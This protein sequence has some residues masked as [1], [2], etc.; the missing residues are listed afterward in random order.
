M[1]I[2]LLPDNIINQ[3]AAGEVIERPFSVVKELVENAIDAGAENIQ[4]YI[5]DGGKS[6]IKIVDDGIGMSPD[7]MQ[8][9]LMRHATSKLLD[10]DLFAIKSLGFRGEALPSIASVS[11][12]T[13]SSRAKG[14]NEAWQIY[15]EGGV[16]ND[17]IPAKQPQK[18]TI[19]EINDLF[20]ATPA[21]LKFLRSDRAEVM[22]ITDVINRLAMVHP[23]ISFTF[24]DGDK[25]KFSY[26]T[27]QNTSIL[28]NSDDD[29]NKSYQARLAQIM[30]K[31]F[32]ENAAPIHAMRDNMHLYG[33]AGL[34]T[35]NRA[36]NRMQFLFV[37]NRPIKDK[38]I[39]GAI[40]GAYADF[41]ARDRHPSAVIYLTLPPQLV[42]VNVHPQKSDVRFR[43]PQNVR[44][45]LVSGIRAA[46]NNAGHRAS[47]SIGEAA[48]NNALLQGERRAS[49]QD[50][51]F[52][53]GVPR[54]H[55]MR[56]THTPSAD[57]I[58]RGRQ[59]YAPAPHENNSRGGDD[60][61]PQLGEHGNA[62]GYTPFG[63]DMVNISNNDNGIMAVRDASDEGFIDKNLPPS[64]SM[65]EYP[66]G[67]AFA[68]LHENYIIAQSPDA[69][70]IV[71]QHAAH[72]RL[73][74]EKMKQQM[75]KPHD[76]N[77]ASS[78]IQA[79]GLLVPEIV[80][81]K[82]DEK[83]I[84]LKYKHDFKELG[85]EIDEFGPGALIVRTTPAL[86]GHVDVQGLI[87]DLA[88]EI[89]DF[90]QSFVLKEKL[91]EVFATMAC[92]GS[93][94]SG[95][96]LNL[97]EMNALLR[98]MEATPHSGQCNHGRPTYIEL[99]LKDI[100]RLFGRR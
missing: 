88:D 74:Y 7:D 22:A 9:A 64:S 94:R 100:E 20:F 52:Q 43:D 33:Y 37:N 78:A 51:G 81:L 66:L 54:Q 55:Y 4:I 34:P 24:Y 40:R 73:L 83:K 26:D 1:T 68:Q 76:K 19:I 84:L 25:K 82:E 85:L 61:R 21:R 10:D 30:G 14:G 38:Q 48:L 77:G 27:Q 99:K 45:L 93:I 32:T 29:N 86:L 60:A 89:L 70:V 2:R 35:M 63:D 96:R 91:Q 90:G 80:D 44:G 6:L 50:F 98:E 53:P 69:I 79:Q 42:D 87:R 97:Q 56:P 72:E 41:L 8:L 23:N 95:R 62:P 18:G 39:L 12:M 49:N 46:L 16:K 31:E 65:A 5:R 75:H 36:N 15:T 47:S 17:P 71:D 59:F 67:A 58:A 3:I 11:R 92:H 28:S 13:L 57:E